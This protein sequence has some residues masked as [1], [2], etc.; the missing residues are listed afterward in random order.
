MDRDAGAAAA[1]DRWATRAPCRVEV[2]ETDFARDA[3]LLHEKQHALDGLLLANS[4]HFVEDADAV[5]G[6]LVKL[7]K[8][9]G[10]VVLV[11]YDRRERSRWVP[12]PISLSRLPELARAAGLS[13]PVVT[14]TRPSLYSGT[15]Y[16]AAADRLR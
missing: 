11:E 5:L 8:P 12:Y 2:I 1:L 9:G 10:R 3:E 7:L 14:A 13:A 15:L 4:L 16:V 6:R